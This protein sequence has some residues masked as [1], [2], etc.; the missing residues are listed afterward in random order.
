MI[1]PDNSE[2]ALGLASDGY[3]SVDESG[4][5]FAPS[6]FNPSLGFGNGNIGTMEMA[7][8]GDTTIVMSPAPGTITD[9]HGIVYTPSSITD[10]DGNAISI[11]NTSA[12]AS[13]GAFYGLP[14]T[15]ST[16]RSIPAPGTGNVSQCPT[17][18]AAQF[19]PLTGA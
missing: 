5:Y 19:Q 8:P 15:D 6:N 16:G 13:S 3:R 7:Y 11:S 12:G 10:P 2:H 17:L 18:S 14:A 9:P 1:G 4:Y